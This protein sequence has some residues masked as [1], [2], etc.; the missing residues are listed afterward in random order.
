MFHECGTFKIAFNELRKK[1]L[2][3]LFS[4]KNNIIKSSLSVKSLFML[5][6]A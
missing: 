6:D 1:A 5:F 2:R 3:A 4:L